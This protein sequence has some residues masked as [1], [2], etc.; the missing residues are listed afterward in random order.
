MKKTSGRRR[1]LGRC[2]KRRGKINR[3]DRRWPAKRED[4][5]EGKKNNGHR[6]GGADN[7]T[8]GKLG[9]RGGDLIKRT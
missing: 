8:M 1:G 6:T 7:K 5:D 2:T 9:K 4:S 3:D